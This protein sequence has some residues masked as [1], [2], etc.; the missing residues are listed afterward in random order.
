MADLQEAVE[1]VV[2]DEVMGHSDSMGLHGVALLVVVVADG[3]LVEVAHPPLRSVRR[4]W[5]RRSRLADGAHLSLS[6]SLPVPA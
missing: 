5:Q 1:A 4:R 3:R 2:D 6:L